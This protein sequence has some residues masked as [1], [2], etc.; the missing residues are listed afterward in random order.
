[1]VKRKQLNPL[2]FIFVALIGLASC[3][4]SQTPATTA[5]SS[6]VTTQKPEYAKHFEIERTGTDRILRIFNP[7]KPGAVMQELVFNDSTGIRRPVRSLIPMSTSFYGYL[8]KLGEL[9]T[10]SGIEDKNYVFNPELLKKAESGQLPEVGQAGNISIERTI[11]LAPQLVIISGTE[12]LGPN[13]LKIESSGIPILNNMDWQEQHPLGRAEWI[14]V[15]GL[16]FNK[17]HEADSIFNS[18]KT[19]YLELRDRVEKEIPAN[20]QDVLLGYNYQGTWFLP[21]GKSYVGQYLRDAGV[22]YKYSRDTTTGSLP[23]N[24]E[25]VFNDFAATKVW[26][27]PGSCK[28]LKE[29]LLLDQRYKNLASFRGGQVFNNNLRSLPN[30]GNDFWENSPSNP[31]IVLSDLVK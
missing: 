28:N 8:E 4:G 27:N 31:D 20:R 19:R 24:A 5:V 16:L 18:I 12:I 11:E 15:F 7:W 3:T 30:G 10:V 22:N 1:M 25:L 23:L 21:G 13:L 2:I 29:L 14:K 9:N 17:E 6:A 26:I